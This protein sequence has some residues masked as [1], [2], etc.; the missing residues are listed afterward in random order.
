MFK[1]QKT[2]PNLLSGQELG[3]R[4][5]DLSWWQTNYNTPLKQFKALEAVSIVHGKAE[6]VDVAANAVTASATF[7]V[8]IP[9]VSKVGLSGKM[10]ETG[11][12]P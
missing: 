7:L 5:T 4:L 1:T 10:P 9:A 12:R 3:K 11:H 8:R 2:K 6:C